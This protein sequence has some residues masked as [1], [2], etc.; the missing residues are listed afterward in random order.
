MQDLNLP[1]PTRLILIVEDD[2]VLSETISSGFRAQGWMVRQAFT[3]AEVRG[4]SDSGYV[5]LLLLDIH[6]PD[7]NGWSLLG[8][9]RERGM[10]VPVVAMSSSPV[11]RT[12]LRQNRVEAFLPKPF[13]LQQLVTT[14]QRLLDTAPKK[15]LDV[16]NQEGH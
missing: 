2:R 5:S 7:G 6:L 14:V 8:E 15:T 9:L 10:E 13:G 11:A 3:C 4:M 16:R 12:E 1:N